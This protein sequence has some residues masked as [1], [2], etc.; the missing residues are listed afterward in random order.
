MVESDKR[1]AFNPMKEVFIEFFMSQGFL[2]SEPSRMFN[3]DGAE[4]L[5]QMMQERGVINL[6]R[7]QIEELSQGFGPELFKGI[8]KAADN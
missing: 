5:Y 7:K 4:K 8:D 6:N 3:R 2:S 1:T